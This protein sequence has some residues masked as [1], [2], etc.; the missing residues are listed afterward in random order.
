[1]KQ[2]IVKCFAQEVIMSICDEIGKDVFGIL[3]D[4]S[5]DV[6]KKEQMAIVLRYVDS[7]GLVKE[8][9]I[10]IVHVTNTSSLTLKEAIDTVLTNNNLSMAQVRG[11]GYDGA[12][13]MCGA[14]NGL[15]SLILKENKSAHYVHCFA[16]QLQLVIVAVAKK[17]DDAKEFFE[18]LALVVTVVCG[19]CKR[20]DMLLEMHKKRV[21]EEIGQGEIETGKGL[22]Q[23]GSL[24]RPGD[25]RWGSHL[26][27]IISL[28]KL[29]PE[30]VK[31]L[32]YIGKDGL[33]AYNRNQANGI[34]AYFN[35][36][37][38]VFV[39]HL[40]LEILGLTD[41]LSKHLQRKD[42]DILEAAMLIKGTKRA[43]LALRKDGFP[44]LFEKV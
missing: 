20:N 6:S 23:E 18:Q 1:M 27:T 12:S 22:N 35:T 10:G 29:F 40:M 16:H 25:T 33:S 41:T 5:S 43:L 30:V 28:M 8:R 31:V 13:N 11:Q 3:I 2:D 14:F 37:E 26:R 32:A 19:S 36:L 17:H 34:L 24:A 42:Q 39:L 21:E 4:E 38:F 7:R 15:K 9:F 44:Q